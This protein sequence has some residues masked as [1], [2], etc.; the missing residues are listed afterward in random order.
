MGVKFQGVNVDKPLDSASP[1]ESDR[2]DKQWQLLEKILLENASEQRK[3]RRWGVL[4]KSL[5]FVYLFAILILAAPLWPAG[6]WSKKDH[7][8]VVRVCKPEF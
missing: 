2:S 1:G 8:A 6:G 4:F 3:T 5:T 7:V